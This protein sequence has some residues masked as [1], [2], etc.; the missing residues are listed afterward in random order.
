[1]FEVPEAFAQDTV[2]REGEAGTAWLARLPA[3]VDELLERWNCSPDGAAVHGAVGVVVPVRRRPSGE[4]AVL[5]VSFPHPGND[6]EP[7]A[8]TVWAG[9][10]AVLLHERDDERYAMLL[11]RARTASLAEV[12]DTDEVITVGGRISRLLAVPAPPELPRLS[13]RADEWEARLRLDADELTHGMDGHTVASAIATVRELGHDQ[14]EVMVHGDLHAGNILRAAREPWLAIDPKGYVGDPAYDGGTLLK[15]RALALL[16]ADDLG[17]AVR[18][19]VDMFA[20]AAE[21]DRER[22]RRWA[23]FHAVEAAFW[24][25]RHGFHIA[26]QHEQAAGLVRF[27]DELAGLLAQPWGAASRATRGG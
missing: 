5:K 10:G 25:R 15:A 3:L 13:A 12:E 4:P 9:R 16:R 14:P 23:Q 24:G 27:A 11:E 6:H 26:R 8:F 19:A 7:H 22:A 17:R 20:E 21:V 18:R 1:M 2:A